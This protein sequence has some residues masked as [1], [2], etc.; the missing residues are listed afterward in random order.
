MNMAIPIGSKLTLNK[1]TLRRLSASDMSNVVGSVADGP[2]GET[3]RGSCQET[4][5]IVPVTAGG[6]TCVHPITYTCGPVVVP[7]TGG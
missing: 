2:L 3:D 1:T 6:A 7:R 5:T 4:C